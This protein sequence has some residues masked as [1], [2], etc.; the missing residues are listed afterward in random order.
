MKKKEN[1]YVIVDSRKKAIE[2][3]EVLKMFGEATFSDDSINQ[4]LRIDG[5]LVFSEFYGSWFASSSRENRTQVSL[6]ELKN[7]LAAEYLKPGD[8]VV[9]GI[10][11]IECNAIFIGMK[12]LKF[13]AQYYFNGDIYLKPSIE[14]ICFHDF[15]RYQNKKD[16]DVAIIEWLHDTLHENHGYSLDSELLTKARKLAIKLRKPH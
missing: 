9:L 11:D 8:E 10:G 7:I 4:C 12:G 15:R 3:E 6:Q 14:T 5:F 13:E 1:I 2:L 16:D